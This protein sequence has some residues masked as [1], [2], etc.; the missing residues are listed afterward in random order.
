MAAV[1]VAV[2]GLTGGVSA[3]AAPKVMPEVGGI[4]VPQK[5][6][7]GR[8]VVKASALHVR[9]G[10]STRY[11]SVGIVRKGQV[12]QV[13]GR[14]SRGWTQLANR[15][16]V[17]S[18]YV[19]KI[20]TKPASKKPA[21]RKPSRKP[22][23]GAGDCTFR[24]EGVPVKL[25]RHQRTVTVAK[26]RGTRAT[27]TMVERKPGTRCG[28]RTVFRDRSGRIGYGG[29]V[30]ASKRRQDTGTTP[31]G[32]FTVTEAFGLKA[33]P[34]TRLPYRRPGKNSYWVLDPSSSAYNSWAEQGSV[35]FDASEGERLRDYPG[36]YNYVAV[37]DYNRR[38]AVKGKGGAIFLHVHGRGATAG[39]V[40]IS[41]ANM[42][43]F[44]R[45]VAAG[46]HITIR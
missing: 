38:P 30:P 5:T 32:T 46:D 44:L 24:L 31:Q 36:Q 10:P 42:K 11:R 41:E 19:S 37:I 22:V 18:R 15:R 23:A 9:T 29:A 40:S 8:V 2:V 13:S 26:T 3:A 17:S 27:V 34:G 43:T 16:W 1:V 39:C 7:S 14:T 25:L 4:V 6:T 28:V 45:H 21:P 20:T 33:D 35:A 12:L